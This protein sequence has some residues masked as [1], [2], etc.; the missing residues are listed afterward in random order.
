MPP[1][2]V[3]LGVVILNLDGTGAQLCKL[4]VE[5]IDHPA[6]VRLLMAR[7]RGALTRRQLRRA[8]FECQRMGLSSSSRRPTLV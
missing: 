7:A 5:V 1:T 4:R 2:V 3:S 8:A 6:R